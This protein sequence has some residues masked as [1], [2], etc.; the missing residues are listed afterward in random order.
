MRLYTSYSSL[1]PLPVDN[2]VWEKYENMKHSEILEKVGHLVIN[3]HCLGLLDDT[4]TTSLT[5]PPSDV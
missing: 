3:Q 2:Q 4:E 1:Y 5:L